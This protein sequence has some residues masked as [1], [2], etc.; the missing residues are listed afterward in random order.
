MAEKRHTVRYEL[1][2]EDVQP[3]QSPGPASMQAWAT[4]SA[5]KRGG[6]VELG[7]QEGHVY[8]LMESSVKV[9]GKSWSVSLPWVRRARVA[10]RHVHGQMMGVW[11]STASPSLQEPS[12]SCTARPPWMTRRK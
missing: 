5:E 6:A 2:A 10:D 1:P 7:H 9:G 3:L 4:D 12:A 8:E 11:K